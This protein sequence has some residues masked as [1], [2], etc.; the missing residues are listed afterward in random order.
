VDDNACSSGFGTA[1]QIVVDSKNV[2][3]IAYTATGEPWRAVYASWTGSE[4]ETQT[5]A[6]DSFVQCLALDAK[7]NPHIIYLD[8][9]SGS[10]K[11]A[12]W[13][14][15]NGVYRIPELR[16]VTSLR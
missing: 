5:L 3:H 2:P 6:Q 9:G 8:R 11:Y 13:T 12:S 14:G 15:Q 16:M 1:C 10:F 4:W 7:D